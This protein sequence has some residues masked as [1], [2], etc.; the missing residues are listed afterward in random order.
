MEGSTTFIVKKFRTRV[1]IYDV[2]MTSDLAGVFQCS[3]LSIAVEAIN[4]TD[5]KRKMHRMPKWSSQ[6]SQEEHAFENIWICVPLITP[7]VLP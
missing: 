6:E 5:V 7:L 3:N 1:H 2:G 4:L